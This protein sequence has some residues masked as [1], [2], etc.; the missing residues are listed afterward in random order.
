MIFSSILFRKVFVSI[1]LIF[2]IFVMAIMIFII[3]H[4]ESSLYENQEM[5]AKVF[6]NNIFKSMMQEK[7]SIDDYWRYQDI[8]HKKRLKDIV[9]IKVNYIR[10]IIKLQENGQ[11]SENQV[12]DYIIN[13]IEEIE[14]SDSGEGWI[15]DSDGIVLAHSNSKL[16][17]SSS[18][19]IR[20][21][22]GN[23]KYR[24]IVKNLKGEKN[25]YSIYWKNEGDSIVSKWIYYAFVPENNWWVGFEIDVD[26]H[27]QIDKKQ[28]QLIE[29]IYNSI[30]GVSYLQNGII[31]IIN[32]NKDILLHSG[33]NQTNI[34]LEEIQIK[35]DA[36]V[37]ELSSVSNSKNGEFVFFTTEVDNS[38]DSGQQVAVW[39]QYIRDYNWDV[40]LVV[41][42]DDLYRDA[43]ELKYRIIVIVTILLLLLSIFVIIYIKKILNHIFDL[44]NVSYK[45]GEG[46]LKQRSKIKRKDEIG[47][48]ATSINQMIEKIHMRTD[49]L[50]ELND[51]YLLAKQDAEKATQ[52]KSRFLAAVSHDLR[53]PLSAAKLLI[54]L[55][56]TN[57]YS[58]SDQVVFNRVLKSILSAEHMIGELV[59]ISKLDSGGMTIS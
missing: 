4:V 8:E 53:Q 9:H 43:K 5:L 2:M 19:D 1:Q 46:D 35:Y 41:D 47:L 16:K 54:D 14:L 20:D 28:K 25:G 24:D 15:I 17:G 44:A 50:N 55:L 45:V 27:N 6:F 7:S 26:V 59:S 38:Q 49:E 29:N 48:L 12:N 23:Y 34:P 31:M 22:Y 32:R 18:L 10:N 52:V 57:K 36:M 30:K 58:K 40:I 13:N 56:E 11:L 3:P 39:G 33:N 51:Q 42:T 37:G 21:V